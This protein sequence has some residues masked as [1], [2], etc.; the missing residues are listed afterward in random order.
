MKN[1]P[2]SRHAGFNE[3]AVAKKRPLQTMPSHADFNRNCKD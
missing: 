1:L 2:A 3:C